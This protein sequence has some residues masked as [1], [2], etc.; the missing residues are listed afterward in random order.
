M[1]LIAEQGPGL[2]ACDAPPLTAEGVVGT[3]VVSYSSLIA[4]RQV[5]V[6]P[7]TGKPIYDPPV[8]AGPTADY[9]PTISAHSGD[10]PPPIPPVGTM[11]P[12]ANRCVAG[13]DAAPKK[14]S[15]GLAVFAGV[16]V[17]VWILAGASLRRFV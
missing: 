1:V 2:Y 7:I 14:S 15:W 4:Q 9:V 11:S 5:G 3:R 17:L 10:N 12:R 8:S 16:I 6:D 13:S